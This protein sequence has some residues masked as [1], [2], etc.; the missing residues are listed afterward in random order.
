MPGVVGAELLAG[1]AEGLAGVTAN[2]SLHAA[3]PRSA[4]EGVQ[5]RPD[6]R[7]MKGTLRN[8]RDQELAGSDF[9]FHVADRLSA[10]EGQPNGSPELSA[11]ATDV[12]EGM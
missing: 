5:I 1:D 3:T 7:V 12:E 4:V 8:T 2:D 10:S 6:R 11:A 9:V